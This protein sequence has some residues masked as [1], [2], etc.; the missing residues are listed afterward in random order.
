MLAQHVGRCIGTPSDHERHKR[1]SYAVTA[2]A[3]KPQRSVDG[4]EQLFVKSQLVHPPPV[5]IFP[6][7][8]PLHNSDGS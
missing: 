6:M 4:L 8:S 3:A 1:D 7:K 5:L 2:A